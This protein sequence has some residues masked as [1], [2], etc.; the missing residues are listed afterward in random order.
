[1]KDARLELPQIKAL[2]PR[3]TYKEVDDAWRST[4]LPDYWYAKDH[5]FEYCF[6]EIN[7]LRKANTFIKQLNKERFEADGGQECQKTRGIKSFLDYGKKMKGG[8]T[9]HWIQISLANSRR[10]HCCCH[11]TND[12]SIDRNKIEKQI[13]WVEMED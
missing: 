2:H 9:A 13:K 10:T 4:G 1:M 8:L 3:S 7:T 5:D 6:R 11:H 12:Y